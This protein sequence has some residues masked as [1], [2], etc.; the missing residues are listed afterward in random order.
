M[1][2]RAKKPKYVKVSFGDVENVEPIIGKVILKGKKMVVYA[3]RKYHYD[4]HHL[5]CDNRFGD[6]VIIV[7]D[8]LKVIVKVEPI[9]IDGKCLNLNGKY[10]NVNALKETGVPNMWM[11]L[12]NAITKLGGDSN[13][14][15]WG[16]YKNAFHY[17]VG[18]VQYNEMRTSD[19]SESPNQLDGITS[20]LF[21]VEGYKS[22][23]FGNID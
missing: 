23:E 17:M 20:P 18:H 15:Y 10:P 7:A 21:N 2:G 13:S 1:S 22:N 3:N 4:Y 11:Y 6:V 14:R 9:I 12:F 5:L 8:H 16:A 19:L